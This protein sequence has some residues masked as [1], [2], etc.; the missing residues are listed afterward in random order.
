M[1]RIDAPKNNT[2]ARLLNLIVMHEND[3]DTAGHLGIIFAFYEKSE[4]EKIS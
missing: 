1:R 2:P 4:R 3:D